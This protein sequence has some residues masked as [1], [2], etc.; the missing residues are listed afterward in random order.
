MN[1]KP[2]KILR[3]LLLIFVLLLGTHFYVQFFFPVGRYAQLQ[4]ESQLVVLDTR[5]GTI[6]VAN[7]ETKT[8]MELNIVELAKKQKERKP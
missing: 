7:K 8:V 6:Y 4:S 5:T 1:G 3:V 2:D